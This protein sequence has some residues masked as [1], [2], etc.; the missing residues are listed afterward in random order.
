MVL[1]RFPI[2]GPDL[3]SV[4]RNVSDDSNKVSAGNRQQE[5][6]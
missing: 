2:A 3:R 5:S 6:M 1:G 4:D